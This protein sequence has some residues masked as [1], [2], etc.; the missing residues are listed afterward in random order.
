MAGIEHGPWLQPLFSDGDPEGDN[1]A[2]GQENIGDT[3]MPVGCLGR[4]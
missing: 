1:L 4:G 3:T 2:G